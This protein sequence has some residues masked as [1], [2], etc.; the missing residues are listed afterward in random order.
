MGGFFFI[1]TIEILRAS[2]LAPSQSFLDH[3][4]LEQGSPLRLVGHHS[5]GGPMDL[6]GWPGNHPE[7]I[8]L[9]GAVLSINHFSLSLLGIINNTKKK[10]I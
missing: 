4:R 7:V 3:E 1:I 2:G 8:M 9:T 6:E 5:N 10:K